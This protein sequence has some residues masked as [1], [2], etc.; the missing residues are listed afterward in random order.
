MVAALDVS[1]P[2]SS[3]DPLLGITVQSLAAAVESTLGAHATEELEAQLRLNETVLATIGHDL[4]NP[5]TAVLNS[6]D[7]MLA[8][9]EDSNHRAVAERIRSSG[10]RMHHLV[11]QLS[12]V[13]RAR[14]GGGIRLAQDDIDLALVAERA[15]SE[16]RVAHPDR[17]IVVA[18]VGD[19]RGRW[20]GARIEQIV[21]NLVGNAM[22]HGS[23]DE[24]VRVRL[25]GSQNDSV[26]LGVT[27]G[28]QIDASVLPHLFEPFHV[29]KST[30]ARGE[31]LG[32]GLYIVEQIVRAHGGRIEVL[33]R[34]GTTT[35]CV[36]LPRRTL[37]FGTIVASASVES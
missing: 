37:P 36:A 18:R 10:R 6:A 31:G 13:A 3:A 27:N 35:F 33:A 1:G 9:A 21:S 16:L 14:L 15:L 19:T 23:A 4:R 24:P 12:D 28:G 5:L 34:R 22:R 29:S 17:S 32:L 11:D 7:L 20:D 30:K 2:V 26:F 25:D 8:R